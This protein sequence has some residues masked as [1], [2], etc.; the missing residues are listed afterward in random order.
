[1]SVYGGRMR[2]KVEDSKPL[3]VHTEHKRHELEEA[4]I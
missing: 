3:F 4:M 1:M 2:E